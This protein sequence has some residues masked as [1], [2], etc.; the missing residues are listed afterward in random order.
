MG[1]SPKA[2]GS[3]R[4]S[5]SPVAAQAGGP[6]YSNCNCWRADAMHGR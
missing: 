6:S 5:N 3:C 1:V 2:G 4:V